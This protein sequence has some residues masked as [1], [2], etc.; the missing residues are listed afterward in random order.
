MKDV[1]QSDP[2][3]SPEER[4]AVWRLPRQ[5]MREEE[6]LIRACHEAPDLEV[7]RLFGY[8]EGALA[9][10]DRAWV[11][12]EAAASQF[13]LEQLALAVELAAQRG[14]DSHQPA[15]RL[16]WTDRCK[17]PPTVPS[18]LLESPPAPQSSPLGPNRVPASQPSP[19]TASPSPRP[20]RS[21]ES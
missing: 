13:C 9:P 3:P 20:E 16:S 2:S 14:D 10:D 19:G 17:T 4:L 11:E 15:D 1:G 5:T 21:R 8:A 18:E 6:D 12:R 7:E